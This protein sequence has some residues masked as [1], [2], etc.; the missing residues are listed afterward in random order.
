MKLIDQYIYTATKH[1][2]DKEKLDI[3][4]AIRETIED[5]LPDDFTDDD[6][7]NVLY[8]LGNPTLLVQKYQ[9]KPKY[10]VGPLLYANYIYTLKLV[11]LIILCV[12][13]VI[14]FVTVVTENNHV[15][16]V[17]TIIKSISGLLTFIVQG[18]FQA[19]AWVTIIFA[20]ID[21]MKCM[22]KEWPFTGK[23]W[24]IEDLDELPSGSKNRI[25]KSDPV[26]S[27]I[28][29]MIFA[30]VI[31]FF[32]SYL[33]WYR[34]D[35]NLWNVTPIFHLE[36]L[37]RYIP[38]FL[39]IALLGVATAI[40]KLINHR[41]TRGLAILNTI[42]NL[43]SVVVSCSFL[44]NKNI[45]NPKF[46]DLLTQVTDTSLKTTVGWQGATI[47]IVLVIIV[48]TGI[49]DIAVGFKKLK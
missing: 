17:D 28:F 25:E 38:L 35:N 42:Y 31:C 23:E 9:E 39:L 30:V 5:M 3:E 48:V 36:V 1:L 26:C 18:A 41:W 10:L 21:R 34:F 20:F 19:F 16:Y 33:G 44:L 4:V 13:P 49:W 45:I 12:A 27:I 24:R 37:N 8:E 11:L 14:A 47:G 46:I 22:D 15:G 29:T 40:V 43:S 6:V 2:S 32:P 7:R